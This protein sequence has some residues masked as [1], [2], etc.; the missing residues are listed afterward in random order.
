MHRLGSRSLGARMR[1]CRKIEGLTTDQ[2]ARA[3]DKLSVSLVEDYERGM[4]LPFPDQVVALAQA[5]DVSAD[6]LL[7]RTN[8]TVHAGHII[9]I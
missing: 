6:F 8:K 9:S 5:Y 1:A 4:E 7:G 2:A 3:S